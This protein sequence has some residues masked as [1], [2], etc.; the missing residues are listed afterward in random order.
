[1]NRIVW[2]SIMATLL[3]TLCIVGA[4]FGRGMEMVLATGLAAITF[5]VLATRD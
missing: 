4:F 1:M 3:S 5:A 2:P